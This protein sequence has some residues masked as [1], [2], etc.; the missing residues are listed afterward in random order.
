MA[1]LI[2]LPAK[3]HIN[4]F[5]LPNA[6][7][8]IYAGPMTEYAGPELAMWE[9]AHGLEWVAATGLVATLVAPHIVLA[10][11]SLLAGAIFVALSVAVVLAAL[12]AGRRHGASRHRFQRALLLAVHAHLRGACH[13]VR[14][15]HEVPVMN[16]LT[17]LWKNLRRGYQTLLFPAR[18]KVTARFRGL[19]EFD[20]ALL[21]RLRRLQNAL[22]LARHRHQ[23]R[24]RRVHLE[25]QP[26]PVHLLRPLRGRLHGTRAQG[27]PHRARA[28]AATG[29]AADLHDPGR[30]EKVLHRRPPSTRSEARRRICTAGLQT[31]CRAPPRPHLHRPHPRL[32]E[33]THN[34][35]SRNPS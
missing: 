12:R 24:Q 9:L 28:L 26:R 7:Q 29:H 3:L 21:H 6:E 2:C 5:S 4:P 11:G 23:A 18:P 15:L 16:I 14:A 19:V 25:L 17:M 13:L 33:E 32:Q 22:H 35:I 34:E 27:R 1:I 10:W 31:G 8:E 30:A 20:P